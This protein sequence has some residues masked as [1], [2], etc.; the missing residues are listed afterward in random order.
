MFDTALVMEPAAM[1]YSIQSRNWAG[2]G[3]DRIFDRVPR[4]HGWATYAYNTLTL[5]SH[6]Q[7]IFNVEKKTCTGYEA[8]LTASN[9]TGQNLRPDTVFSLAADHH[10]AMYMDWLCRALHL[11]NYVNLEDADRAL[12]LNVF[13]AVAADDTHHPEMLEKMFD[14]YHA[15]RSQVDRKSVV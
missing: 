4:G 6:F 1:Q 15:E 11:R 8:L 12:F 3:L 13:P 2:S 10:E 5:A 14:F 9:L 7:P